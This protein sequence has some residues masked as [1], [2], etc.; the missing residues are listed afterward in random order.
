SRIALW[1]TNVLLFAVAYWRIDRGG[2]EAGA[3]RVTAQPDWR[4]PREEANDEGLP[5][6]QPTFVDYLS[7]AFCT[8]T[9]FS[10]TQA[11]AITA[12]A[13]LLMMGE[14]LISLVTV[15]AIVS[16]AIGL[17]GS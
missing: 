16:R 7:L 14:S 11:L 1:A 12:R 8:A 3:R 17:L 6:W 9:V 2:E 4:F 15:M 10:P 13:K 5:E